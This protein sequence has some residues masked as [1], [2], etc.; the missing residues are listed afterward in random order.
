MKDHAPQLETNEIP[1][2]KIGAVIGSGGKVIQ[3]IQAE[4]GAVITI[5]EEGG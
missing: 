3:E 2:D 5:D 1:K 4:T